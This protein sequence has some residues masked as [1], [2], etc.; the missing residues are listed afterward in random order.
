L[1][2]TSRAEYALLAMVEIARAGSAVNLSSSRISRKQK[3]PLKFLEQILLSLKRAGF[4]LA[5]KGAHGGYRLAKPAEEIS[6]A[7]IIR[8]V[9][10]ALAPTD[11][12]SRYF[13]HSTPIEK[14]KKLLSIFKDI[15]DYISTRLENTTLADLSGGED[16]KKK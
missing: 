2:L 16:R 3:I 14:E 11:S 12:A 7:A 13:Y 8:A 15:R 9:D 6:L 10:G 5:L 4:I 1:R